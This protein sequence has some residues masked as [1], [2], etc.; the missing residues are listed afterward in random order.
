[1]R[2]SRLVWEKVSNALLGGLGGP[3]DVGGRAGGDVAGDLLG[4][5]VDH[6]QAL[7]RDRIDPLAVDVE[8]HVLAH[9]GL[10]D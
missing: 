10:Q 4:G 2:S 8:L 7:R 6:V 1:M 5:G 9:G 3:V